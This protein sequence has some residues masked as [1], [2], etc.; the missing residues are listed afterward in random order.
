VTTLELCFILMTSVA[1][2]PA[3]YH[4]PHVSHQVDGFVMLRTKIARGT[5]RKAVTHT[6]H[7]QRPH[8]R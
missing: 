7:F 4:A 1:P 6:H 8:R 5:D 3:G 2:G